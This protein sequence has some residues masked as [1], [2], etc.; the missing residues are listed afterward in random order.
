MKRGAGVRQRS[1][2]RQIRSIVWVQTVQIVEAIADANV[3][4][5]GGQPVYRLCAGNHFVLYDTEVGHGIRD[6]ALRLIEGLDRALPVYGGGHLTDQKLIL[7]FIGRRGDA[8]VVSSCLFALKQRYPRIS[9]DIA[10]PEEAREVF[11]LMP[12]TG[13]LLSYPLTVGHVKGYDYYMSFEEIEAIPRGWN[14]SC[15]DVFSACLH[16]PRPTAPPLP[17]IPV[18]VKKLW[19]LEPTA[20]PRIAIHVG[21]PGSLRSYPTDLLARLV[22]RLIDDGVD[23]YLVGASSAVDRASIPDT[24]KVH[25]L[26][27][28]T[29]TPADLAAVLEQ[30]DAVVTGDSFPLHLAGALG[31]PT[32]APFTATDA[33]IGSDYPSV[34]TIQSEAGC[35]PC[36]VPTGVCPHGHNECV[37]HHEHS[38]SPEALIERID[39]LMAV[40]G[41]V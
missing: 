12:R 19:A 28:R 17:A 5:T 31:V 4:D 2:T 41:R 33:V 27:G 25:D 20:C 16:T 32:I 40:V 23:V 6:K 29:R 14:R 24:T 22:G 15:A 10:A 11:E 9:I 13:E 38:L 21:L 26:C 30:M 34:V 1:Q 37:A 18:D 7:P 3:F 39:S 35:S 36:H 8:L